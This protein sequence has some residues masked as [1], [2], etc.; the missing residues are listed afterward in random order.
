MKKSTYES[1]AKNLKIFK[2]AAKKAQEENRQKGLPNVYS[3][4]GKIF[5]EYPDGTLKEKV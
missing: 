5:Y 3:I 1:A 2:R 4:K